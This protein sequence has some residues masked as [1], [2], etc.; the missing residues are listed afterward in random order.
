MVERFRRYTLI[1][2]AE[3]KSSE[4]VTM[5]LLKRMAPKR[6]NVKTMTFEHC[7]ESAIH[8]FIY[9]VL[10]SQSSFAPPYSS[11]ERGRNENT[12]GLIRQ[13]F[14]NYLET[15][16]TLLKLSKKLSKAL[17]QYLK[18]SNLSSEEHSITVA[19]KKTS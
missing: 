12:H 10:D 3:N 15:L 8:L 14:P 7:K 13:Y 5:T 11:W 2:R 18:K 4:A 17:W 9:A 1:A 6:D 19:T 16:V